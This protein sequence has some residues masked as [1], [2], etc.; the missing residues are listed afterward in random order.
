M[1][2]LADSAVLLDTNVLVYALDTDAPQY[3][4]A[5]SVCDA[6]AG[7]EFPAFITTQVVLEYV[8]V[9]TSPKRVATP[10]TL[11]EAWDDVRRFLVAFNLL[12][13]RP[14][15]VPKVALLSEELGLS[16][17]KVFDLGIAV[18]ALSAGV[19]TVCTYDSSVFARVPGLKVLQ[20]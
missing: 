1:K 20:P 13:L 6:A 9:V 18:T 12:S 19:D 15:D 5:K 10:A 11:A 2:T 3:E 8:S 4:A 7:G 14:E 17:P 16:G